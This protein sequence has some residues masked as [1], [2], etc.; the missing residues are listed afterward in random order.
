MFSDYLGT[1]V[2]E[3]LILTPTT[4][5]EIEEI[6][7]A[8]ESG[9]SMGWD[10][11]SPRVIKGVAKEL[12][13]SL[14][15]LYNCCMRE[16]HYPTCFKVA[17][18]VPVYKGEDP[19]EFS[20]YRPVS[21]LPVLSQ[22]FEKVIRSRLI[23]FLDRNEVLVAG[24]YGFR[25]GHSTAMAVLD[26]VEKIR[27]AWDRGNV[28]LGVLIDLKKAFDTVDHSVLLAKLEHYG[29][30]GSALK[31]LESYLTD[32][33]QYVQYDGFE[34]DKGPLSCGV[35]Q[36]S[37]LGPLFFLIY[38]NDMA[39]ACPQLE[40]VLFA[41]DTNIFAQGKN[42]SDVFKQVNSGLEELSRWF[43]C[44]KLTLNLKKTEYL[45]FGGPRQGDTVQTTL[46]IGGERIKQVEGARFL[47]VWIDQ[48]LKWTDHIN[49]VKTKVS[50]L[51]G[52]VGRVSTT[53]NGRSLK[54]LYNGIV[55]PHLQYCLIVWG[56]FVGGRNKTL[57]G[58][59]LKYQKKF[60]GMMSGARGRYHSDPLFAE[61]AILKVDDLYR[62]QLRM[63]AWKFWNGCLPKG[64]AAMFQRT[65]ER[66]GYVTR[67]AETGIAI[68]TRNQR[69]IKYRLPKEW[70]SILEK[71]RQ[72]SS[73]NAFKKGSK[74]QLI[75]QYT[76]FE[77]RDIGCMV[78]GNVTT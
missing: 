18:V 36:G 22:I 48:E 50:Q 23:R 2:E 77:C 45:F 69:S 76:A 30:R 12:S 5:G 59:L 17:R 10:A 6:C 72:C 66:H 35:P 44:N 74:R 21:V 9:K 8:L 3:E 25:P 70:S 34:S 19:T 71:Q 33:T 62:Q 53:L 40:L 64:Q 47:G 67:S 4:P 58:S 16:G 65:T 24:Q 52:V 57:A 31:L 68:E 46:E 32:R 43:R 54:T 13:G 7:Q 55:L 37:V 51:L 73:L 41:D 78:C 38:V 14:S 61:N 39:K 20:N 1:K 28:A 49:K 63:Y 27:E 75:E 60:V 11:V 15:R 56:D 29:V 26:M 42:P